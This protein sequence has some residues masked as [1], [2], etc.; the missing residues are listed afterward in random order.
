VLKFIIV[1]VTLLIAIN[2][3]SYGLWAWRNG[4]KFGAVGVWVWAWIA[5]IAPWAVWLTHALRP[6]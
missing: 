3:A 6:H 5:L 2:T 4:N 1:L